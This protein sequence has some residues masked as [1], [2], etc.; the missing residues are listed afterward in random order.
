MNEK[1]IKEKV[2]QI[3]SK[4][5]ESK[6]FVS[7]IDILKSLGVLD[8]KSLEGWRFG[9][10]Q[11]LE[12]VLKANLHKLSFILETI[13]KT[14]RDQG[15]K[16]SITVYKG[17]GKNSKNVLQFTKTKNAYLEKRYSLSFVSPNIKEKNRS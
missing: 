4:H 16:E 6:G 5:I 12:R 13:G 15:L 7:T 1:E 11:Y 3:I 8:D 2:T 10:V 9:R 17:Y 14:A